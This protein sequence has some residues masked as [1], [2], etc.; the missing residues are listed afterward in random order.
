MTRTRR[1]AGVCVWLW[2]SLRAAAPAAAQ[3][4]SAAFTGSVVDQAGAVLPGATVTALA[5][6]TRLSRTAITADDGGYVVAGLRTGRSTSCASS[7]T[8]SGR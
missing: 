6:A 5:I 7:S 2:V 8:A 3:I 4:G 1:L